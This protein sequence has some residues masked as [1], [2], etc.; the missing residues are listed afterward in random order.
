MALHSASEGIQGWGTQ[1]GAYLQNITISN[2]AA[3]GRS[4]RSYWH[5]GKWA[6]V[7]A[8]LN[9]GDYVVI[10]F[11]HNDGGTPATSDR[12]PLSDTGDNSEVVARLDDGTEET[13][14]TWPA[15]IKF[16]IEGAKSKGASPIISSTTPTNPYETSSTINFTPGRFVTYAK[17]AAVAK[18]VPYIDHFYTLGE[19]LVTSY[20]PKDH[21]HTNTAGALQVAKAFVGGIKCTSAAGVL[22][23]YLN[24]IGKAIETMCQ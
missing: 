23:G 22:S 9:T 13:V 18:G 7:Q 1:I 12:A 15:Y 6:A 20:F 4:A 19:T 16:M 24:T 5:E 14:Y 21:T 3:S 17:D 10:E 8:K 11:G 2:V